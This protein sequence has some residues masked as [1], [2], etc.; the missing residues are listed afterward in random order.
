MEVQLSDQLTLSSVYFNRTENDRILYKTIDPVT[1]ESQYRNSGTVEHF[2]GI[3]VTLNAEIIKDLLLTTN[4]TYTNSKEG[5][6]LRV[7]T[8]KINANLGY[9]IGA[10]THASLS[11]QYVSDRIDTDFSTFS[12]V[13]LDAFNLFDARIKHDFDD[14]FGMFLSVANLFNE[15]Y[16]ELVDFTTKGRNVHLGFILKL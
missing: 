11:Y 9:Q 6:A 14:E 1:F 13:N 7:P 4:Y 12:Q 3:E 10:R 2:D 16:L 5:L 8:N 15:D